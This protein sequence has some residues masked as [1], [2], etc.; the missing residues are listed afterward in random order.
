MLYYE[1]YYCDGK[2]RRV[3]AF[4]LYFAAVYYPLGT[5]RRCDDESTSKT[6]I[7]RH[8]NVVYPVGRH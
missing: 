1:K 7:Q 6:L 5:R 3:A 2:S 4:W 8:N